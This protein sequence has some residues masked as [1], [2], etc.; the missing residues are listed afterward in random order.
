MKGVVILRSLYPEVVLFGFVFGLTLEGI[1]KKF[2]WPSVVKRI[3]S[4]QM[5]RKVPDTDSVWTVKLQALAVRSEETVVGRG[6]LEGLG[7]AKRRG[8]GSKCPE[9]S[10]HSSWKETDDETVR[11]SH[12]LG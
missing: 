6:L 11:G 5:S 12:E 1:F 8:H 2:P 7:L 10:S 3:H 4:K 9:N